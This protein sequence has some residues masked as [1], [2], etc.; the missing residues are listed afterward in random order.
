MAIKRIRNQFWHHV[1]ISPLSTPSQEPVRWTYLCSG[2][3]FPPMVIPI[4]MSQVC[5]YKCG[6][7]LFKTTRWA[8][9]PQV[10]M[11]VQVPREC[12]QDSPYALQQAAFV[13]AWPASAAHMRARGWRR[14]HAASTHAR[15]QRP[16]S[17]TQL[18]TLG[19]GHWEC[20]LRGAKESA[21][22]LNDGLVG[23]S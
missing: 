15:T 17:K 14:K 6:R 11:G 12:R 23:F 18:H 13:V 19:E 20:R 7:P 2:L 21:Y 8:L 3:P 5:A 16:T 1:T 9:R 22:F 10:R 4:R